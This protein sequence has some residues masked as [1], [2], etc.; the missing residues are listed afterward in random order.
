MGMPK[1]GI[2]RPRT[3]PIKSVNTPKPTTPTP[4]KNNLLFLLCSMQTTNLFTMAISLV[5][6]HPM[7]CD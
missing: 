2:G 4:L 6:K 7:S 1:D 3:K 5:L